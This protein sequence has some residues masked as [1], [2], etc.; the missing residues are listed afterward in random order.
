[1][2]AYRGD[3]MS[4]KQAKCEQGPQARTAAKLKQQ[5]CC[6]AGSSACCDVG[7]VLAPPSE[8]KVRW[9]LTYRGDRPTIGCGRAKGKM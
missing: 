8:P 3:N 6:K 7:R 5:A 1:V 9:Q 2:Q 4:G